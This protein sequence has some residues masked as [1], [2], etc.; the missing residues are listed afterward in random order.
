VQD[1]V[2]AAAG[3]GHLEQ[4]HDRAGAVVRGQRGD[5]DAV[6]LDAR[7]ER[8]RAQVGGAGAGRQ[9]VVVDEQVGGDLARIDHAREG[10]AARQTVIVVGMKMC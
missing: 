10:G 9:A 5:A 8:Q 6:D 4:Q 3:A 2:G 7:V 1:V